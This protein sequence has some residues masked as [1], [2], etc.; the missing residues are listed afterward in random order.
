MGFV[1]R[2]ML[3]P[4]LFEDCSLSPSG[5]FDAEGTA[6]RSLS[7]LAMLI[8]SHVSFRMEGPLPLSGRL[9]PP[10]IDLSGLPCFSRPYHTHCPHRAQSTKT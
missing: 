1:W 8:L 6:V 5:D 9:D 2:G 7:L 4:R 10:Q 3:C